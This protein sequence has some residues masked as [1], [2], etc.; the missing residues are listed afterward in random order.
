[1]T[2]DSKPSEDVRR[3]KADTQVNLE[4]FRGKLLR[5]NLRRRKQQQRIR[6]ESE[7]RG[8]SGC[9]TDSDA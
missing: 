6:R 9:E 4:K 8:S 3:K 1:M 2:N 5:D 7:L